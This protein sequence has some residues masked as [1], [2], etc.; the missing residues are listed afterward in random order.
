MREDTMTQLSSNGVRL[1][2][3]LR[4][5]APSPSIGTLMTRLHQQLSQEGSSSSSSSS[6]AADGGK[7]LRKTAELQVFLNVSLLCIHGSCI[8]VALH[9]LPDRLASVHC[10]L[11]GKVLCVCLYSFLNKSELSERRGREAGDRGD[12]EAAA[13]LLLRVQRHRRARRL[14]QPVPSVYTSSTFTHC[15]KAFIVEA[16]EK[17]RNV[18]LLFP[19][20]YMKTLVVVACS[21]LCIDGLADWLAGL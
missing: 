19:L 5:L 3:L 16:K 14:S 12:E 10:K 1:H 11:T 8:S 15:D 2:S 9:Y 17:K 13:H 20:L 18:C 7:A 21:S 4:T 6:A